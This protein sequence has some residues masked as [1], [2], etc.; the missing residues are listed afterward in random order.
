MYA[1][2]AG[3]EKECSELF[4]KFGLKRIQKGLSET[5]VEY[6]S[7]KKLVEASD[8]KGL[9]FRGAGYS[10][11]SIQE[12]EFGGSGVNMPTA[13]VYSSL[14]TGVIDACEVG[15]AFSNFASAYHEVTKYWGFP[16]VHQPTQNSSTIINLDLW[17][18]LPE[19]LQWIIRTCATYGLMRSWSFAH[20]EAAKIIPR[21]QKEFGVEIVRQSPE[22]QSTWKTVAWRLADA[23]A[24]KSPE[25]KKMWDNHKALMDTLAPYESLQTV[26]YAK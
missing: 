17:N 14:Q 3:G 2:A 21:L 4:E 12:P 10:T 22:C 6:M 5:E 23:Q 13:D 7:N 9:T 20:L 15:N 26:T 24:A 8:Y 18:K 1:D 16:G 25:F 19:D 11:L